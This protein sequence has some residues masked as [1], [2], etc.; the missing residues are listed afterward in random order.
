MRMSVR[1]AIVASLALSCSRAD[2]RR[3]E[4][5]SFQRLK[6]S[7]DLVVVA[8]VASTKQWPEKVQ[9]DLFGK[10]LEGQLTTFNVAAV[11]KGQDIGKHI[12]VVHYR[13]KEGV[14]LQDGPI[15]ACFRKTGLRLGIEA[16]DGVKHKAEVMEGTPYYLLFLKKRS[17]GK[18]EPVSGQI[19]SGLSVRKLSTSELDTFL[20]PHGG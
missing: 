17:D 3:I 19:D 16:V 12:E 9:D 15:L 18:Y 7:A 14:L 8:S 10:D 4:S 11:F 20:E 6:E 5:W 2:A 13:V 1:L